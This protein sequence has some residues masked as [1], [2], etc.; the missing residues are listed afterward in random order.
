MDKSFTRREFAIGTTTAIGALAASSM[1]ANA[2]ENKDIMLF[3]VASGTKQFSFYNIINKIYECG[4]TLLT[5]F[6]E[7]WSRCCVRV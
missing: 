6:F 2:Q 7:G 1:A 5:C 3:D 4:V